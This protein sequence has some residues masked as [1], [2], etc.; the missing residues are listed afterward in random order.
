MP[1][2]GH[3]FDAHLLE[4]DGEY[5]MWI[6]PATLRLIADEL[7]ADPEGTAKMRGGPVL[8][9]HDSLIG[10]RTNI[11]FHPYDVEL[12]KDLDESGDDV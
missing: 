6:S 5:D 9:I 11:E 3:K 12:D 4:D 8:S 1:Q 7:E 10:E 2:P